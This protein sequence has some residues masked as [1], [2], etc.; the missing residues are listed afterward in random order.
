[1]HFSLFLMEVH[2]RF[3]LSG[4]IYFVLFYFVFCLVYDERVGSVVEC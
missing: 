1:M 3:D 2:E 4:Q